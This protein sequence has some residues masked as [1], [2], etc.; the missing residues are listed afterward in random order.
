MS[1]DSYYRPTQRLLLSYSVLMPILN[2]TKAPT[3]PVA[4]VMWLDG[5]MEAVKSEL[6][7]QYERAYYG[8]RVQ[9]RFDAAV[10]AGKASKSKALAYC[11]RQNEKMGRPMRWGDGR[12]PSSTNF[13][14]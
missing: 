7:E 4:R 8:A 11:R 13:S 6:D 2:L 12:D 5:V 10:Q 1:P 3:D 14:G 9:G